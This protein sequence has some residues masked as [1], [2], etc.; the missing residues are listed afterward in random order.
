MEIPNTPTTER[1]ALE[2]KVLQR[3][4]DEVQFTLKR[5]APV[6]WPNEHCEQV[7][8]KVMERAIAAVSASTTEEL[9]SATEVHRHV[10]LAVAETRRIAHGWE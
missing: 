10:D 9:R 6:M 8:E 3:V 7:Q 5:H 1:E 2:T 4:L